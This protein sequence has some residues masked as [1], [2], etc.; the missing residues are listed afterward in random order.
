[1]KTIQVFVAVLF[2]LFFIP[3]IGVHVYGLFVPITQE[4][5]ASH[6]IHILSYSV[7]LITFLRPISYR[8]LLYSLAAIYPFMFHAN[9]FFIPLLQQNKFN[10]VCLLVIVMLPLGGLWIYKSR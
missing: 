3:A 5:T 1:M 7:C 10:A 6:I 2:S 8:L 4:S 9:C